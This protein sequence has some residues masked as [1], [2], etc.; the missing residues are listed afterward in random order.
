MATHLAD[1]HADGKGAKHGD[2]SDKDMDAL[3]KQY[4]DVFASELPQRVLGTIK[5]LGPMRHKLG[6]I[7]EGR[8][9]AHLLRNR[10]TD[11]GFQGIYT[12]EIQRRQE[13]HRDIRADPGPPPGVR[14]GAKGRRW[15][16]C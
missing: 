12:S 1:N 4:D 11:S 5:R 2:S 7:G 8:T 13:S 10:Y 16:L 14:V 9:I 3:I 6:R 15:P